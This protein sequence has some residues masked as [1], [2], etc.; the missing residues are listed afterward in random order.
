MRF[1]ERELTT[2][3]EPLS[4]SE[5]EEGTV[6]FSLLYAD[7]DL[8]IPRLEPWVFVGRDLEDGDSGQVYFQ[9]IDSYQRGIRYQSASEEDYAQFYS[10][11][12][13]E[14]G[15]IFEYDKA[16]DE[17]LR[18]FLKRRQAARRRPTLP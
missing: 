15:H 10:G 14:I 4:P 12:E 16:L 6:Y 5:L 13:N 11:S 7:D 2:Y 3:S 9:D 18:C 8:L 17:L 1:E